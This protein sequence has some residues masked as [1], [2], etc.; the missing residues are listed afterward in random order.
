MPRV[1]TIALAVLLTLL[2]LG[3]GA[4][5]AWRWLLRE[6]LL[7]RA[8]RTPRLADVVRPRGNE[9]RA[10]MWGVA[11]LPIVWGGVLVFLSPLLVVDRID[12]DPPNAW[13]LFMPWLA[14]AALGLYLRLLYRRAGIPTGEAEPGPDRPVDVHGEA[15]SRHLK[16]A[17]WCG[18]PGLVLCSLA[19]VTQSALA[20]FAVFTIPVALLAPLV[21]ALLALPVYAKG[22]ELPSREAPP[23][24]R[25]W[26]CRL[27]V[28]AAGMMLLLGWLQAAS[29]L[30]SPPRRAPLLERDD[31]SRSVCTPADY[32]GEAVQSD[33]ESARARLGRA[34]QP[35]GPGDFSGEVRVDEQILAWCVPPGPPP[36]TSRFV[37]FDPT[38]DRVIASSS[39]SLEANIVFATGSGAIALA[40]RGKHGL[41]V[42]RMGRDASVEASWAV[43]GG[44]ATLLR[45][46]P[47]GRIL[48]AWEHPPERIGVVWL[49]QGLA[50]TGRPALVRAPGM[51]A[52]WASIGETTCV[53]LIGARG[54]TLVLDRKGRTWTPGL[55]HRLWARAG[56]A[57]HLGW[58][59]VVLAI[60]AAAVVRAGQRRRRF[61][62]AVATGSI[63]EG[64]LSIAEGE[65]G[66]TLRRA[67][68]E[69][70]PVRME[71]AARYGYADAEPQGG[72]CVIV[73]ATSGAAG[74]AYRSAPSEID[75]ASGFG[76]VRGDLARSRTWAAVQ[77]DRAVAAGVLVAWLLAGPVL[78][79]LLVG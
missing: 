2:S 77:L 61:A 49:G 17:L 1:R 32:S 47:R 50:P 12:A 25:P 23:V 79:A 16:I 33:P 6:T 54:A 66:A 3:L 28:V 70:V 74:P 36:I 63:L 8:G 5:L 40:S 4:G 46:D 29:V 24:R 62:R 26:W 71:G 11:F 9:H 43:P 21:G 41:R 58:T 48:V 64:S 78:L 20:I 69:I 30:I 37:A 59:G 13:A 27:A 52:G 68:G 56:T 10:L 22:L 65:D 19:L 14:T 51:R 39:M 38:T 67:D 60:V 7:V 35:C 76:I 53:D 18:V 44:P 31:F 75:A 72:P 45:S 73:G 42:V 57:F 55:A 34:G 15:W